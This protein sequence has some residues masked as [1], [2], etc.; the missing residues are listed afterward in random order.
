MGKKL[1]TRFK[2]LP[3]PPVAYWRVCLQ[4]S[5]WVDEPLAS[6]TLLSL[7]KYTV[8]AQGSWRRRLDNMRSRSKLGR[9]ILTHA[10]LG[11]P[12]IRSYTLPGCHVTWA[13]LEAYG[14]IY[15]DQQGQ[16]LSLFSLPKPLE[17]PVTMNTL[18]CISLLL[19]S[20]RVEEDN[21]PF[22]AG[23]VDWPR[24]ESGEDGRCSCCIGTERVLK[25]EKQTLLR[26]YGLV[27]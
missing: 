10:V 7:L 8:G 25:Y 27:P 16:C 20:D 17:L 5:R 9:Q 21:L 24:S 19:P 4:A 2:S 22:R 11:R 26:S 18:T 6:Q 1:L 23:L 12:V 13:E 15:L 3:S 14:M